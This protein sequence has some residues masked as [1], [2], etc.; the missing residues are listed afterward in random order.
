MLLF[1]SYYESMYWYRGLHP[2]TLVGKFQ[3]SGHTICMKPDNFF[4]KIGTNCRQAMAVWPN[5]AKW[6]MPDAP[7]PRLQFFPSA[8]LLLFYL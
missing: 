6:S 1:G 2:S 8:I 5:G 4:R 7:G 3:S